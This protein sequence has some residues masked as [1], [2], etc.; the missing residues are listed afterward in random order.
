MVV[1]GATR[2]MDGS[3]QSSDHGAGVNESSQPPQQPLASVWHEASSGRK[4]WQPAPADIALQHNLVVSESKTAIASQR[5]SQRKKANIRYE[6]SGTGKALICQRVI[7]S[8]ILSAEKRWQKRQR[9]KHRRFAAPGAMRNS[10]PHRKLSGKNNR[11]CRGVW[12]INY[13]GVAASKT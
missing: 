1:G 7:V 2:L 4:L 3:Q 9:K 10:Q 5:G 12:R 11:Y 6:A 13:I 8:S